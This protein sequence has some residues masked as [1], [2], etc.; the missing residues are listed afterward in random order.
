M[1]EVPDL[2]AVRVPSK[3][4]AA[5]ARLANQF[6]DGNESMAAR[7]L[8]ERGLADLRREEDGGGERQAA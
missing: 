4:K 3:L 7:H 2:V 6:Y 8:L 5:V 1:R